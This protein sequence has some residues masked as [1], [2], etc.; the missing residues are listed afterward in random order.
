ML[1]DQHRAGDAQFKCGFCGFVYRELEEAEK[2][3]LNCVTRALASV[4]HKERRLQ[5]A[6][7]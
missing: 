2:C 3:E 1:S 5:A 6:S 7:N 4:E